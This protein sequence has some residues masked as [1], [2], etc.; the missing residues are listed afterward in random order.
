MEKQTKKIIYINLDG[1]SYSYYQYL[2]RHKMDAGFKELSN[3]GIFLRNLQSGLISITNP[4]QSAILSGSWSN[5]T[6]NFY[7]HFD[8]VTRKVVKHLR[9]F[10]AQNVAQ[11]FLENGKTV[12]SIHQFMLEN[13]PCIKGEKNNNYIT[14][15]FDRSDYKDRFQILKKM[16]RKEP[17]DIEG[18]E[19]IYEEL[20]DFT[21]LYIDDLDSLGHNNNYQKYDK[22]KTFIEREKDIIERLKAIQNEL[23]D[24]KNICLQESIYEDVIVL[25]TTDHGMTPFYGPSKLNR[26]KMAIEELNIKVAMFDNVGEDTEIVLLPYT[27]ECSLYFL[28]DLSEDKL[29]KLKARLKKEEYIDRVL[30]KEEMMKKHGLDKRGP[31]VLVSPKK[32]D[33]FYIKDY[34]EY[35]GGN[36]D[37][38]DKTSQHIFGMVF[39]GKIPKKVITKKVTSIDLIPSI[40]KHNNNL[41]LKDSE[42]TKD[43]WDM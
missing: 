36:H 22:R 38:L 31:D 39:G 4:M 30:F 43:F 13:N 37:S 8:K 42:N 3:D 24:I 33:H 10:A 34:L 25:V 12:V 26:L 18:K 27:I 7:Q 14:T 1:F 40:I 29:K 35:F 11:L 20:P 9:T 17:I 41:Y 19:F 32:G 2:R 23:V 21:A 28:T 16:I 5:K 15:A 6:H